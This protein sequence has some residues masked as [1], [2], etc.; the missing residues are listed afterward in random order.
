[1]AFGLPRRLTIHTGRFIAIAGS[2]TICAMAFLGW[3]VRR[4][5]RLERAL[6]I[7][8]QKATNNAD[9]FGF[10][11]LSLEASKEV[12]EAVV[13]VYAETTR[14]RDGEVDILLKGLRDITKKKSA[15]DM[16]CIGTKQAADFETHLLEL[17]AAVRT[18]RAHVEQFGRDTQSIKAMV[19]ASQARS[20]ALQDLLLKAARQ[21][22][23]MTGLGIWAVGVAIGTALAGLSGILLAWRAD[24]RANT[25]LRLKLENTLDGPR[26]E[27][28]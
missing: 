24:Y 15:G 10:A 28:R 21:S 16:Q 8:I 18:E 12:N 14:M 4:Q 6:A 1:M 22:Q 25:E 27:P 2:L 7:E 20:K 5:F 19:A 13:G 9:A 17:E 11:K 26:L 23:E 3:Y